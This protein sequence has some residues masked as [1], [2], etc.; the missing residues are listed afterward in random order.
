MNKGPVGQPL[1]DCQNELISPRVFSE[2]EMSLRSI[3]DAGYRPFVASA[4]FLHSELDLNP[5]GI[6]AQ[7]VD[8]GKAA[9]EFYSAYIQ[10]NA[11]TFG[12]LAMPEWVLTDCVLYQSAVVDCGPSSCQRLKI[13]IGT[14]GLRGGGTDGFVLD[15]P[16]TFH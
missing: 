13:R 16:G 3:T 2:T 9:N 5:F 15:L 1:R 14:H 7:V 12:S 4:D 10:A 6:E 8:T 11:L